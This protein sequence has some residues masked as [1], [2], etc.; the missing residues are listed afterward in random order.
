MRKK[1]LVTGAIILIIANL[2]T[3]FIGFFYRIYMSNTIG[4]EGMGLYQLIMPI[5]MLA[6]SI[7]SSGFTT[8]ISKLTAQENAKRQYG[9]MGRVLKQS[10][11]IC[12]FISFLL[13]F[14]LYFFADFISL[15]I[16]QDSRTILSLKILALAFPFMS[17]GSCIRGYFFG[18]QDSL[19]PALSQVLEQIIRIVTIFSL[20]A[21]FIPKGLDYACAA[22]VIGIVMGEI[23]SFLFVFL[24]YIHFKK[25]NA[26]NKKPTLSPSKTFFTILSMAVPL[27]AS[28]VTGSL[29]ST[30]ENILIPQRLQLF[31]HS[32]SN[33]M[34]TYGSLTGMAMPLCQ[35]PTAFLMAIS[36]TLVPAISEASAIKN[37]KRIQY[38]TTRALLFT[39]MIGIGAASVF[40]VFSSEISIAVYNQ[41]S[42]SDMLFKLA[43]LCPFMY[44]QITLTGLL[45]GLGEHFLIFKNNIISSIIN[46]LFIY[47]LMPQY[48][49]HAFIVGWFTSLAI[50]V[51]FSIRRIISCTKI[52]IEYLTILGKPILAVLAS[53]LSA[54]YLSNIL[55]PTRSAFILCISLMLFLYFLFLLF[56]GCITKDDIKMFVKRKPKKTK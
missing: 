43:F 30:V 34:S 45:N 7:T 4:S 11:S 40:A 48:G 15:N 13:S 18:L 37:T 2:T 44:L 8:T 17:S 39:S 56:L 9:N 6:W 36:I 53:G 55:E 46:I 12:I 28:R 25:K 20:A 52:H 33:A 38:T 23:L 31:G 26:L 54:R 32:G 19:I 42:V 50:T 29:L 21:A 22:A 49:I 5:Y 16:I 51:F 41:T 1:S 3:R 47:F 14:L 10:V 35:F 24:S 27:T